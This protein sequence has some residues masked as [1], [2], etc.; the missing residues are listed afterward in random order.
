MNLL[1]PVGI[2]FTQCETVANQPPPVQDKFRCPYGAGMMPES[3]C[4]GLVRRS[5]CLRNGPKSVTPFIRC[6]NGEHLTALQRHLYDVLIGKNTSR[7]NRIRI[8]D[9]YIHD[10]G[11]TNS[12]DTMSVAPNIVFM[13]STPFSGVVWSPQVKTSQTAIPFS[14]H[15]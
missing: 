12:L 10:S 5:I 13:Y 8:S 9:K 6:N 3:A 14:G 11:L 2:L 7:Y 4:S 1:I 15:V